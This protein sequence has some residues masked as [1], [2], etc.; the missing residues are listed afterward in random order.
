VLE[1]N[2]LFVKLDSELALLYDSARLPT[3]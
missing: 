3:P 1:Y 2:N